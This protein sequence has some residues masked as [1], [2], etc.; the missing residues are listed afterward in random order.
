M[1]SIEAINNARINFGYISHQFKAYKRYCN[2]MKNIHRGTDK[3]LY[4]TYSLESNMAKFKM[5]NSLNYLH[6]N[7]R[8]LKKFENS[9]QDKTYEEYI[10]CIIES[11]KNDVQVDKIINLRNKVADFYSFLDDVYV[12]NDNRHDFEQYK[13]KYNWHDVT[14][15]FETQKILE[16]FLNRTFSFCDFRFNTQLANKILDVE[17][18]IEEL[19]SKIKET[20][21]AIQI[22]EHAR[23]LS[24]SI[25]NLERFLS[26]NF[27]ESEF[28]VK[29]KNEC[30]QILAYIKSI[31]DY[32][33]GDLGANV[34]G[35]KT[36]SMFK[37]VDVELKELNSNKKIDEGKLFEILLGKVEKRLKVDDKPRKMPLLPVFYDV[38]YD[39]IEYPKLEDTMAGMLQKTEFFKKN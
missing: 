20:K 31:L 18:N 36:P 7:I 29:L 1:V 17:R 6:K 11:R 39:Y 38:A 16:S 22:F 9:S 8:L 25:S 4:L 23:N 21:I 32:Q 35:F 37:D 24:M 10:K 27:V 3:E 13:V 12:I 15:V 33:N 14:L 34:D 30:A 5:L 2:K 28:I 26:D 19:K